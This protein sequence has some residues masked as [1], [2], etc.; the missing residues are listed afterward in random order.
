MAQLP[1]ANQWV[2]IAG[3]AEPDGIGRAAAERLAGEL[4]ANII[5]HGRR[6]SRKKL[7]G[8]CAD[9]KNAHRIESAYVTAD[10]AVMSEIDS[11]FEEIKATAKELWAVVNSVGMAHGWNKDEKDVTPE[12]WGKTMQVIFYAADRCIERSV[13]LMPNGG[14]IINIGSIGADVPWPKAFPYRK[15][16]QALHNL[17]RVYAARLKKRGILINCIKPGLVATRQT[18]KGSLLDRAY[19]GQFSAAIDWLKENFRSDVMLATD[20]IAVEI[21]RL[22]APH[23]QIWG[24]NIRIDRGLTEF[25]NVNSERID[26]LLLQTSR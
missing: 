6:S 19:N 10:F 8:A 13:E 16:K 9:L 26:E 23:S 2:F 17:T 12:E 14:R 20:E 4:G 7:E 5:L 24:K 3:S 22:C 15:A 18:K 11:M 1:L 21:V 25:W